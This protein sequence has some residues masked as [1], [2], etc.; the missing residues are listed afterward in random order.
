MTISIYLFCYIQSY[1]QHSF[2]ILSEIQV[3]E[4][5]CLNCQMQRAHDNIPVVPQKICV[6]PQSSPKAGITPSLQQKDA[7]TV[8]TAKKITKPT[9]AP[10]KGNIFWGIEKI[11]QQ[12]M[13]APNDSHA[14]EKGQQQ[15]GKPQGDTSRMDKSGTKDES[16]F[17]G[18]GGA[19]SRSPSP[20]PAASAVTE[21][22]L[23]FGTS[24]LSSASNMISSAVMDAPSTTPP[25]TRKGSSVSQG[26]ISSTTPPS[27]RKGSQTLS[28]TAPPTS[29]K[30]S[31][32]SQTSYKAGSSASTQVTS[33]KKTDISQDIMKET[34]KLSNEKA[35]ENNS[36]EP[37]PSKTLSAKLK[38]S[39]AVN[40]T[41]QQ[42]PKACP[43]CM[44]DIKKDFPNYSTC[45]ECRS[46]VCNLCGFSPMPQETEVS[47][48]FLLGGLHVCQ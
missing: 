11:E 15:R 26:S 29:Y 12:Q 30:G 20:K 48:Y 47:L 46:I 31:S 38:D 25:A 42:L 3:T 2:I 8:E 10:Q 16:G 37:Q 9:T 19:R 4:W 23:G 36:Q 35:K 41:S 5:L 39:A 43:L 14:L 32:V 21:K 22:V 45:T 7:C 18:F 1:L 24:F 40:T 17:F 6:Q 28:T 33:C 13:K 44:T 34:K 27:S